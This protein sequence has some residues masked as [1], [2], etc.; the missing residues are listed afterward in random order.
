MSTAPETDSSKFLNSLHP[1]PVNSGLGLN[2]D[3][4]QINQEYGSGSN[5]VNINCNGPNGCLPSID[6]LVSIL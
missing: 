5:S 6:G 4:R 1:K 3:R 2:R